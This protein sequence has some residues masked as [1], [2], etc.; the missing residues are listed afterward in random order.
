MISTQLKKN[1]FNR[2]IQ[3]NLILYFSGLL[4]SSLGTYMYNVAV[5]LYVL[6]VTGSGQKF[7][8]TILFGML[9]R[10]ILSPFAGVIADRFNRKKM[11]VL[12]DLL[13]GI[14]LL[15]MFLLNNKT[16]L[17][18]GW[19][20]FSSAMLTVFNTFFSVTMSASIP[21]IV[22]TD[23]LQSVNSIKATIDAVA[24]IAGPLLAGIV[25]AIIGIHYF[26]LLNGFSFLI[27]GFTE[28]FINFNIHENQIVPKKEHVLTSLKEGFHYINKNRLILGLMKYILIINFIASLLYVYLP[29]TALEVLNASPKTYGLLQTCAPLGFLIMSIYM[30]IKKVN[31]DKIFRLTAI[32]IFILGFIMILLGLPANPILINFD[33]NIHMIVFGIVAFLIGLVI[34]KLNIPIQTKMQIIID[35]QF[36]GRVNGVISMNSQL[37]MPLGVFLY[38]FLLDNVPVYLIPIFSGILLIAIS[39]LMYYDKKLSNL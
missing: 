27:S 37:I 29:Y 21:N 5:G 9:P 38:G 23:R 32:N 12:T 31:V 3:N 6:S 1:T 16:T 19:I 39:F 34:I 24:S 13:S 2:T 18:L 26:I 10:I 35:D 7:A 15:T 22:H 11:I 8:L 33:N 30:S 17:N 20:Y 25:Y 14:L 36:R 28:S 4:I